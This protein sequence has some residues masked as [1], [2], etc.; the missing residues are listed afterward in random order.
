MSKWMRRLCFLTYPLTL[1]LLAY[2]V[3]G[4]GKWYYPVL[5]ILAGSFCAAMA[6]SCAPCE[7]QSRSCAK[8]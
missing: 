1:G 8:K 3:L 4:T 7:E 6:D 5:S 2:A